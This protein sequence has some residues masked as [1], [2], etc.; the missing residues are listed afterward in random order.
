MSIPP[1]LLTAYE[2][3]LYVVRTNPSILLRIGQKSAEL[4]QLLE[5]HEADSAA[6]ITSDNPRSEPRDAEENAFH[7]DRL[8]QEVIHT[9][10]PF[11]CTVSIDP[12]GQWP[13]EHGFLVLDL[14]TS[15][16][17]R[18][19]AL[20]DQWAAVWIEKDGTVRLLSQR[21]ESELESD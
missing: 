7:R 16:L 3:S 14:S 11:L 17:Q 18:L 1:E 10:L 12:T 5:Q 9:Q 20:F 2:K 13:D 19:L 15:E 4:A 21:V 6:L 8:Q